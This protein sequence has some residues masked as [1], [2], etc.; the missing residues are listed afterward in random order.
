M[1]HAG[2]VGVPLGIRSTTRN[3]SGCHGHRNAVRFTAVVAIN[4]QEASEGATSPLTVYLIGGIFSN[5]KLPSLFAV[6]ATNLPLNR[7]KKG[8][9]SH[10]RWAPCQHRRCS[11]PQT[12]TDIRIIGLLRYLVVLEKLIHVVRRRAELEAGGL[13]KYCICMSGFASVENNK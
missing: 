11:C 5:A 4:V 2:H 9:E 1:T 10:G 13:L 3:V 7:I 8:S 6:L 12:N